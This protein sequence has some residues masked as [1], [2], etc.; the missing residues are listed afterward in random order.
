MPSTVTA[1]LLMIPM[2]ADGFIQLKTS[3]VSTNP[4]R[5]ITGF[6]FGYALLVLFIISTLAA[7]HFGQHLVD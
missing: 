6:L 5:L 2:V 1:I 3:Y 4:R 7:Y